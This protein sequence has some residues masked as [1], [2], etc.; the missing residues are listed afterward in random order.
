[1]RIAELSEGSIFID[2]VDISTL[3]LIK[4]RSSIAVI[5]QEPIMLTGT[6]RS[7]LDP[8]EVS[9]DE[10]VWS[11]LDSV[12]LKKKVQDMPGKLDT[13]INEFSRLFSIFERQLFCIAR[14]ILIK[15]SIVIYDEPAQCIDQ[16]TEELIQSAMRENF[17]DVTVIILATRFHVI[18]QCDRAIVMS[19]GKI[20]EFDTPLNLIDNPKSKFSMML[21]QTGENVDPVKLRRLAQARALSK[22]KLREST[23]KSGN[24]E[25]PAS[26][27]GLFDD[28]I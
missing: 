12:H 22:S 6:I 15:S 25:I 28:R 18:F 27:Q 14:A 24:F 2:D 17:R 13:L 1:M 3:A 5:P 19:N 16:D 10:E 4:L 26:L 8:F 11:S 23:T 21:T 7:N 9:T 20:V